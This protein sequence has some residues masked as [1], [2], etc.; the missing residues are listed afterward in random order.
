[1][2]HVPVE[3]QTGKCLLEGHAGK[4]PDGSQMWKDAPVE[5]CAGKCPFHVLEQSWMRQHV[6][7]MKGKIGS[8]KSW[9]SLHVTKTSHQK[10]KTALWKLHQQLHVQQMCHLITKHAMWV[11]II[12]D[13]YPG[14][15]YVCEVVQSHWSVTRFVCN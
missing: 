11:W 10:L 6:V 2:G 13:D 8:V 12:V 1:M 5:G 14:W 4:A 9:M 7:K 3:G 15:C